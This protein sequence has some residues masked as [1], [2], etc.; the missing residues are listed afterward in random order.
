MRNRTSRFKKF[1]KEKGTSKN[2]F[3]VGNELKKFL[4][5]GQ[6]LFMN[7]RGCEGKGLFL[8]IEIIKDL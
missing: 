5:W 8:G 3:R 4:K 2:A 1:L 7:H 6:A